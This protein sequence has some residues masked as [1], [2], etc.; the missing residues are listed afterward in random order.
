MCKLKIEKSLDIFK[1]KY[2]GM[3]YVEDIEKNQD[4][5]SRTKTILYLK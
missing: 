3:K 5:T 1:E 4:G 2:K